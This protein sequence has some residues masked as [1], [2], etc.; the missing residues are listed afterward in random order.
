M[1]REKESDM[2]EARLRR[3]RER[4]H[5][6]REIN[7]INLRNDLDPADMNIEINK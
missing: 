6:P 4:G 7:G 5:R 3:E 2:V 1:S